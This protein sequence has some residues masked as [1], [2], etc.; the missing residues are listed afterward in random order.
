ME[1]RQIGSPS[2]FKLIFNLTPPPLKLWDYIFVLKLPNIERL[3]QSHQIPIVSAPR[4]HTQMK[5]NWEMCIHCFSPH[6]DFYFTTQLC[7]DHSWSFPWSNRRERQRQRQTERDRKRQRDRDREIER[8]RHRDRHREWCQ[9]KLSPPVW[10]S[11]VLNCSFQS[12]SIVMKKIKKSEDVRSLWSQTDVEVPRCI[13]YHVLDSE[14]TS[15]TPAKA[16]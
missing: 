15:K 6:T 13:M 7:N 11:Q 10:T 14:S 4:M 9:H 1:N 16:D 12:P 8:Q 2:I 3:L 5:R